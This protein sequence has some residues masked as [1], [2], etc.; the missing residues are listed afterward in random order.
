MRFGSRD[1]VFLSL[2]IHTYAQWY[3]FPYQ[4][5]NDDDVH[6]NMAH[7]HTFHTKRWVKFRYRERIRITVTLISHKCSKEF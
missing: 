1:H 6:K 5:Q 7:I 4:V 2:C 3:I